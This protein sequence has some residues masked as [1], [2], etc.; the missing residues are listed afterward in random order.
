MAEGGTLAEEV[1]STIRTAQAF[2]IQKIL[3]ELYDKHITSAFQADMKGAAW[4]GGGL[5]VFFFVIYNAY[6]LGTL[7]W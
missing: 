3:S 7:F 1:I 6:A 5:G 2:G 4:H